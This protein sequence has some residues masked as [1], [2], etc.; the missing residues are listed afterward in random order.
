M[1]RKRKKILRYADGDLATLAVLNN[2]FEDRRAEMRM[3]CCFV[4]L[5]GLHLVLGCHESVST[6]RK[7]FHA[8]A[9]QAC[10]R[11][12][13]WSC[14]SMV[15]NRTA[16]LLSSLPPSELSASCCLRWLDEVAAMMQF[17]F[18]TLR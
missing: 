7:P 9:F 18:L 5:I 8:G 1:N 4:I 15:L 10:S 13:C 11:A 14:H 2:F 17:K 3:K 16:E 12:Q 6:E